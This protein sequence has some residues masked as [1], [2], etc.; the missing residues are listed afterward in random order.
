[1]CF[2]PNDDTPT[3]F[4]FLSIVVD[5]ATRLC[6]QVQGLKDAL[7]AAAYANNKVGLRFEKKTLSCL[8]LQ[9]TLQGLHNR[10]QTNIFIYLDQIK[11]TAFV[12]LNYDGKLE[13]QIGLWGF[14]TIEYCL[15]RSPIN[16]IELWLSNKACTRYW[17]WTY[18]LDPFRKFC[19]KNTHNFA[20]DQSLSFFSRLSLL[21]ARKFYDVSGK[22]LYFSSYI[23]AFYHPAHF[24]FNSTLHCTLRWCNVVKNSI[25]TINVWPIKHP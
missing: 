5:V 14:Q 15:V 20:V 25:Y 21:R 11:W 4:G 10:P 13:S 1:M 2:W 3:S 8:F 9:L 6:E 16:T 24:K 7:D 23:K 18:M 22:M 17:Y 19:A 12:F